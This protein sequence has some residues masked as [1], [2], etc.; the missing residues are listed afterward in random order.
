[1]ERKQLSRRDFLGLGAAA[2]AAS[3]CGGCSLLGS[4]KA[5]VV[6]QEEKGLLRLGEADSSGLLGSETSLL[7]AA[8]GGNEKILVVHRPD[9]TLSAVSSVC[10][11]MG[12]DVAYDKNL[13]HLRCPCH[14][15]QYGL[16]GHNIKGPAKKPL[17]RYSVSIENGRVVIT[18]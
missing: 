16:D 14:G 4:Q 5:D 7:V 8:E 15:S 10:T 11:H 2:M 18:L 9:G 17:R 12:C 1:M 13:G 3:A 6:V